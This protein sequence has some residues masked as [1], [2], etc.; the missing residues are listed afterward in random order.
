[1]KITKIKPL[2]DL[3]VS[4]AKKLKQLNETQRN[5][6]DLYGVD[7][8]KILIA[9]LLKKVVINFKEEYQ[10]QNAIFNFLKHLNDIMR[11][12]KDKMIAIEPPYSEYE[13][14]NDLPV[15]E[16]E[17]CHLKGMKNN[18]NGSL[19]ILDTPGPNEFGQSE[20]LRRV[21]KTQLEKAS[22]ILL[23]IDFTQMKNESENDVRKQLEEIKEQLSKDR[24]HVIVNKFDNAD[25]NCMSKDELL[26]FVAKMVRVE[27]SQVF[28]ISAKTA[29]LANRAR[30]HLEYNNQL[31]DYLKEAWVGDFANKALGTLW[32]KTINKVDKED[33]QE[34]IDSLWEDSSFKKPI[35]KVIE[36]AHTSAASKSFE[37][38]V[39]RL[40]YYNVEFLNMLNLRSNV[41][42]KDIEDIKQMMQSLQSDIGRCQIVK[43]EV[44]NK[45]KIA[46]QALSKEMKNVI[47]IQGESINQSINHFFKEGKALEESI[48]NA[49]VK[50]ELDNLG[51]IINRKFFIT[52][53][54][55]DQYEKEQKERIYKEAEQRFDPTASEIIF[56]MPYEAE[57]LTK[58]IMKDI[59]NIFEHAD[60]QLKF[61]TDNLINSTSFTISETIN[62][63]VADT[64]KKAKEK[65]NDTGVETDFSLPNISLVIEDVNTEALFS[66]GYKSKTETKYVTRYKYGIWGGICSFFRTDDWGTESYNSEKKTYIVDIK[67]IRNKV[68]EQLKKQAGHLS[69][70]TENYLTKAFQ[71]KINEHLKNLEEYLERYLGVLADGMKSSELDQTAK[72][73]LRRQLEKLSKEQT[74][75]K[76]QIGVVKKAV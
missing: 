53:N 8:G 70:Q 20:A 76:Q 44:D 64:F 31:P 6:I 55:F 15:I 7:E 46:I 50:T 45:L 69:N 9:H 18:A 32:K 51:K 73:E 61:V 47:E 29:L 27:T 26:T 23:V 16:V 11:L 40:A 1:L 72:L 65:L 48:I 68:K 33:F 2:L 3:S 75:M 62:M 52:S 5:Q 74:I 10:G 35:A 43:N 22:A 42:T 63:A 41:M 30:R 38:A 28:P 14:L 66:A 56:D 49:F 25:A 4:V 59:I 67:S 54:K 17:F 13:N 12:A 19:A 34:C 21:F 24:L 57:K 37:S 36:K 58:N 71:P 60:K 39:D